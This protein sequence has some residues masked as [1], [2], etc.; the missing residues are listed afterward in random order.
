[1]GGAILIGTAFAGAPVCVHQTS[2]SNGAQ[3]AAAIELR[4]VM[5]KLWEEHITYTRNVIIS[6]LASLQ[7]EIS[8]GRP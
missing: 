2:G 4:A 5:R 8:T 3:S 1:L 7:Y 6:A